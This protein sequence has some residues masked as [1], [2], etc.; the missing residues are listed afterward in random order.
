[1]N[2]SLDSTL[3]LLT[4][5]EKPSKQYRTSPYTVRE[6][7]ALPYAQRRAVDADCDAHAGLVYTTHDHPSTHRYTVGSRPQK[8]FANARKNPPLEL[9]A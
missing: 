6:Y 7:T 5:S 1:M 3:V 9:A 4:D 2:D 8:P